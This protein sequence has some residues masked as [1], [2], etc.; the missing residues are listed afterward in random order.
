M[1]SEEK[2]TLVQGLRSDNDVEV[3]AALNRLELLLRSNE[4]DDV[5]L[6]PL[7]F[8]LRSTDIEIRR[9]ASWCIG[10]L[11][12]NKAIHEAPMDQLNKLL[13]DEDDEVTVNAAWAIGEL[14]GRGVGGEGSI[15]PLNVLLQMGSVE[16]RCMAAW[17]LGRL[18]VNLYAVHP[19]SM[20]IL[21]RMAVGDD[22]PN[23]RKAAGWALQQVPMS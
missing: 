2:D 8:L 18:A 14:A 15:E 9:K 4:G 21:E 16:K 20:R 12:Q 5:Y 3:L 23:V 19:S 7:S 22:D 1:T 17:A 11:A 10:K 13:T 6:A